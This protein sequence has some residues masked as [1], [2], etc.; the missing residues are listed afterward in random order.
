M[1]YPVCKSV[2]YHGV[3]LPKLVAFQ[4]VAFEHGDWAIEFGDVQT[5]VVR[6][7]FLVGSV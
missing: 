3:V 5:K 1:F 6:P 7:D 4:V 2:T